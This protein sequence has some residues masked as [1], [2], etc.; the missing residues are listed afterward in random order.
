VAD[1]LRVDA[2]IVGE[3]TGLAIVHA[4]KGACRF[5]IVTRG[6]AAHSSDPS[7][8]RS[9]IAR[10]ARAVQAIEG[11]LARR[12]RRRKHPLLGP[13]TVSVGVIRGG[14]QV[15]V[16]PDR[17][18]IEVDRRTLPDEDREAVA[19]ELRRTLDALKRADR[20][21]TYDLEVIEW[22]PA[23]EEDR[24]GPLGRLVGA[25]AARILGR[26]RFKAVPWSANSGIFRQA[27]IP[28]I[29]FGP[30]SIRQ[31]HTADEWVELDQVVR[32]A[33]VYAEIIRAF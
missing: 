2:A 24:R 32:A 29:L 15:N 3:P 13:P 22:Y 6:R 10:M 26:A 28:C 33:R 25:A 23:M 8:G 31:A 5:R 16:V 21:F 30:G 20:G 14:S 7:R 9:A 27:G 12:L 18:E 4:H 11:P 19:G 17:C 1:G